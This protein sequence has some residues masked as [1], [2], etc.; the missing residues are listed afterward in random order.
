MVFFARAFVLS[1]H[2]PKQ[3]ILESSKLKEF[4]DDNFNFDENCRTFSKSVENTVVKGEIARYEQF[5]LFPQCFQKDLYYRHVKLG[6]VW[7]R[8][9][10][11]S[12]LYL[13]IFNQFHLYLFFSQC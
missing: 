2:F 8:V 13:S 7:E 12:L 3:R 11:K 10:D 5:L 4:A 6:L 9:K 1:E